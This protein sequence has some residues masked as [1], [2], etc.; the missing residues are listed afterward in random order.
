MKPGSD[1]SDTGRFGVEHQNV[2]EETIEPDILGVTSNV[3]GASL[4]LTNTSKDDLMNSVDNKTQNQKLHSVN[5]ELE[6]TNSINS[7]EERKVERETSK[8]PSSSSFSIAG[9]FFKD[10]DPFMYTL[11]SSLSQC[12]TLRILY[13]NIN[14]K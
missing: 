1:E 9:R 8:S 5:L 10:I 12:T 2:G 6:A 13:K 3:Q 11:C 4:S 14:E 7:I